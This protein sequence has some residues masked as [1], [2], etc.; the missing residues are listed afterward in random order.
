MP[1]IA[2]I[3]K[4]KDS[5]FFL[6]LTLLILFVINVIRNRFEITGL[7]QNGVSSLID[8]RLNIHDTRSTRDK[9]AI[10]TIENMSSADASLLSRRIRDYT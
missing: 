3:R 10:F 5:L 9:G 1:G 2:L 8:G 7:S 6:F 4:L